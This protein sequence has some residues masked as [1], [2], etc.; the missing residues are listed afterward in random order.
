MEFVNGFIV[1]CKTSFI[2]FSSAKKVFNS[3]EELQIE[4][5]QWMSWYNKERTHSGK[6]CYGKTPWQ[7]FLD[8]VHLAHEKQL[9]SLP[10]RE[11]EASSVDNLHIPFILTHRSGHA[12]PP[13]YPCSKT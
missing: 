8:T 3:I 4:L 11:A 5:D 12:D 9:D 6:Y 10:W 2:R 7:T 1:R 13:I